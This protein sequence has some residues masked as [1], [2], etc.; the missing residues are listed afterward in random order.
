MTPWC[1]G[2][3]KWR[4]FNLIL[5]TVKV[6]SGLPA[7]FVSWNGRL[8]VLI[9]VISHLIVLSFAGQALT[10]HTHTRRTGRSYVTWRSCVCQLINFRALRFPHHVC[11]GLVFTQPAGFV[12]GQFLTSVAHRRPAAARLLGRVHQALAVCGPGAR[13]VKDLPRFHPADLPVGKQVT[14]KVLPLA[15]KMTEQEWNYV[16][17]NLRRSL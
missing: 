10:V 3:F 11:T 15:E 13:R 9:V 4:L 6:W 12:L 16:F 8:P 17:M 1:D 14:H 5:L 2:V 7:S